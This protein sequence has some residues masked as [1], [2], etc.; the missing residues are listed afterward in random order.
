MAKKKKKQLTFADR[1]RAIKKKYPRAD[2]DATEHKDMINELN[3]L[4]TEQEK[5]RATMGVASPMQSAM[6]SLK[7]EPKINMQP[8]L[9]DQPMQQPPQ[10]YGGNLHPGGYMGSYYCGGG[11]FDD[12]GPYIAPTDNLS[13]SPTLPNA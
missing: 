7:D 12:G 3:N 9:Q 13:V 11:R 5:V 2:W 8:A 10:R 4:K 6:P 1:A